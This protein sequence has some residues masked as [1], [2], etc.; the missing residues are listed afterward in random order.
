[1]LLWPSVG[2]VAS[3]WVLLAFT[4]SFDWSD[5]NVQTE[6]S[7]EPDGET[8]CELIGLQGRNHR[9]TLIGFR[10]KLANAAQ[11]L[12]CYRSDCDE[13]LQ[14]TKNGIDIKT[15]RIN[16]TDSLVIFLL[17]TNPRLEPTVLEKKQKLAGLSS[18]CILKKYT[19]HPTLTYILWTRKHSQPKARIPPFPPECANI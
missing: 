5:I 7:R 4:I 2:N 16:V 3:R 10:V 9:R 13:I 11:T 6:P 18:L 8:R 17:S 15:W 1:M 14:V 19:P 12:D